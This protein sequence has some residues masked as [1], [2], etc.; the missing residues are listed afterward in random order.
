M[1]RPLRLTNPAY[2]HLVTLRTREAR[3]FLRPTKAICETIGGI[4]ARYREKY[5]ILL[6]AYIFLGNHYHMVLSDPCGNL[7]RFEQAVNREISRRNNWTLR[8]E[9][10]LWGRRYDDQIAVEDED[11]VEAL[12]YVML[13]AVRHGLVYHPREWPGLSSFEQ[14]RTGEARD[15]PFVNYAAYARA[16]LRNRDAQI[17]DFTNKNLLILTPLPGLKVNSIQEQ[18]QLIEP[19]M[20]KRLEE[21]RIEQKLTARKPSVANF[22]NQNPFAR[23]KKISRSPRPLCYTKS[24]SAKRVFSEFYKA[25]REA[26]LIVSRQFR[27]GDYRKA[28]PPHTLKPPLHCVPQA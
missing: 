28:F 25:L 12:I 16:R 11:A 2:V 17:A 13:N 10:S 27:A 5:G 20:Q 4:V 23:P 15:F 18:W 24:L 21:L 14:L 7:W 6:H 26:Y 19:R 22:A 1:G 9:G 8:R 3:L